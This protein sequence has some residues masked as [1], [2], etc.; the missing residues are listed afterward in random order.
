[1]PTIVSQP[2]IRAYTLGESTIREQLEHML[3]ALPDDV[4]D[5]ALALSDLKPC[6]N[7]SI[8]SRYIYNPHEFKNQLVTFWN[9]SYSLEKDL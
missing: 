6:A 1:M 3:K 7:I 2:Q 8:N 5:G 4:L 9:I